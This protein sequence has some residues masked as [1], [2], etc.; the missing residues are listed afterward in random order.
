MAGPYTCFEDLYSHLGCVKEAHDN[1]KE[2]GVM[3]LATGLSLP[4]DAGKYVMCAANDAARYI[5]VTTNLTSSAFPIPLKAEL[6]MCLPKECSKSDAVNLLNVVLQNCTTA[7]G[8]HNSRLTAES[9]AVDPVVDRTPQGAGF[10]ISALTVGFLVLLVLWATLSSTRRRRE[11]EPTLLDGAEPTP[12]R[13]FGPRS[14]GAR[15]LEAFSLTGPSGTITK[16]MEIPSYKPTDSLNGVRVL[17][18]I[19]IIIGHT[20]LMPTAISGYS[21][22]EDFVLTPLNAQAAEKNPL[23]QIVFGGELGVDT[24]FFLSGFLLSLLTVRELRGRDGRM[25]PKEVCS[26]IFLRYLRLTPSLALAMLFYSQLWPFLAEG[27]FAVRFQNSILDNCKSYW[28]SEL[29]YTLNFTPFDSTKVCMGWTWYLG[30]DMIFFVMAIVVLPIYC[31]SKI[32]GWAT[33]TG[34][35]VASLIITMWLIFDKNLSIYVFDH[36]YT[37]YSY[38]AYSKPYCRAPAY[39]VGVAAAWVLEELENAGVRRQERSSPHCNVLTTLMALAA[40]AFLLFMVFIPYTDFG[41]HRNSWNNFQSAL[42]LAFGRMLWSASWA[43]ITILTYFG[44]LPIWDSI[45]SHSIWTPLARL[46]YG[47]YLMHPLVIKLI[48]A[49]ETQYYTFSA[50]DL[51]YRTLLNAVL[52]FFGAAALWSLVERP[53]MSL[54]SLAIKKPSGRQGRSKE[55]EVKDVEAAASASSLGRVSPV[56]PLRQ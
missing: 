31:R 3:L 30:N 21:N 27:P 19:W 42:Y 29:T 33:V 24:F 7:F 1:G 2:I 36:H 48:A 25:G 39:F 18:M 45:M 22:P 55:V 51:S 28:W 40:A 37:D 35:T 6:G 47:A 15:I 11:A 44:H 9:S 5:L 4:F 20:Y 50:L 12:A 23:L 54:T 13:D 49:N 17:S 38:W 43:V 41:E 32:A 10:I 14:F 8:M 34:I 16:L 56:S 46:T 53:M 52:A 26:A